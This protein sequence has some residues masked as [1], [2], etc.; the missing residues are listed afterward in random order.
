METHWPGMLV[1]SLEFA[2]FIICSR[3]LAHSLYC[4]KKRVIPVL[5]LMPRGD[6]WLSQ[7]LKEKLCYMVQ[8]Q[9]CH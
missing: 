8:L 3:A 5:F 4:S 2:A 9:Q 7:K 1:L 6:V